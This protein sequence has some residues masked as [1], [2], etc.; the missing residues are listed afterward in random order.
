MLSEFKIVTVSSVSIHC[1]REK[2][3]DSEL[4]NVSLEEINELLILFELLKLNL[5]LF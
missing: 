2:V 1:E 3:S 4:I 5:L